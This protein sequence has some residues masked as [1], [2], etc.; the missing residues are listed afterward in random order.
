MPANIEQFANGEAAFVSARIPAW[1]RLGTVTEGA[2]TAE[3]AG[4]LA[5]LNGWNVRLQPLAAVGVSGTVEVPGFRATV[6]TNPVTGSIDPLGVVGE[7]Y[8]PV[9]NEEAFAVLDSIVDEGGAHFETA[10]SLGTGQRVF[11]SMKMP[12]GIQVGG[13][14]AHEVYLLAFNS[15]D[16][17]SAFTLAVTPVRVVC[18]NTLDLGLRAAKQKWTLRHTSSVQGR[19]EEA[20]TALSLTFGYMDALE[21]ELISFLEQDMT[22]REFAGIVNQLLPVNDESAQ[23]WQRRTEAAQDS[24][25][26]LFREADTNEFGRGTKYAAFNAIT[27]YA[28]W[29]MPVKGADPDG[30]KRAVRAMGGT[31]VQSFK[32]KGLSLVRAA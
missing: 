23:G 32:A 17:S 28:D 26:H 14:D 5:H 4:R 13:E 31:T 19:I 11:M 2:M 8:Q 30:M 10:G 7:R 29:Y 3:E 22:D 16:G 6:R 18:Q 12:Q 21:K 15:H 20:R 25:Y 1:H 24:L 27:E 9:Q